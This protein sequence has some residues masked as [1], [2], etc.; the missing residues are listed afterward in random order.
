MENN[1]VNKWFSLRP[2]VDGGH[3]GDEEG[4]EGG[5]HEDG[6]ALRAAPHRRRQLAVQLQAQL[7]IK[8]RSLVLI[9]G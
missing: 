4:D 2:D 7:K 5:G 9:T 1:V 3:D 6:L 8:G